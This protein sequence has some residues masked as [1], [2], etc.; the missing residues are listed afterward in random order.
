MNLTPVAR[1]PLLG[2]VLAL[3]STGCSFIF[4]RPP[5]RGPVRLIAGAV[6]DCTS[7]KVAPIFDTL[8]VVAEGA[9]IGYAATAPNK[10][11][12]D[13]NQPLSREADIGLGIGFAALFL[14]SAIYGYSNTSRCAR[15]QA[16]IDRASH[17]P[18]RRLAALQAVAP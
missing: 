13:P 9:R 7:S 16:E 14:G 17:P 11:Y 15:R 3:V 8:G 18:L 2:L 1:S 12:D 5:P 10:V 4:V 6:Q